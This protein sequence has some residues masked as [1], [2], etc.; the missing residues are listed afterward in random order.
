MCVVSWT[1]D[2]LLQSLHNP[3]TSNLRPGFS[4]V[5]TL[6]VT[7][8]HSTSAHIPLTKTEHVASTPFKE[9]CRVVLCVSR[10][11]V[12]WVIELRFVCATCCWWVLLG[13]AE[14]WL[15]STPGRRR[16]ACS[17]I[18]LQ[19]RTN[20]WLTCVTKCSFL[21]RVSL[22]SLGTSFC[23]TFSLH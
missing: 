11:G 15:K 4:A 20:S 5:P 1:I 23:F 10:R 12:Q 13:T 2:M 22:T 8:V 3:V 17:A 14:K 7:L 18:S 6:W 16:E 9:G 19:C 21:L